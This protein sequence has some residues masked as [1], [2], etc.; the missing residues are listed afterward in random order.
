MRLMTVRARA[1][2]ARGG[3][4][5]FSVTGFAFDDWTAAVRLVTTRAHLVPGPRVTAFRGVTRFA[6]HVTDAGVVRQP[7]VAAFARS[8]TRARGDQ[9]KLLLVT[10][11]A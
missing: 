1:V 2:A 9:R 5:L 7:A 8:V 3:R 11:L 10:V 6:R 4:E